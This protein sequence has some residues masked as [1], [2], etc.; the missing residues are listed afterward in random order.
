MRERNQE[1][2]LYTR[3][4]A[5]DEFDWIQLRTEIGIG[6]DIVETIGVKM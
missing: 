2:E 1:S 4:D 3:D 5:V 6:V